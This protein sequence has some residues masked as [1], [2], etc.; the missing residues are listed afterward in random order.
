MRQGLS[1]MQAGQ[2]GFCPKCGHD[3]FTGAGSTTNKTPKPRYRCSSCGHR[4]TTPSLEKPTDAEV[5]P[6]RKKLPVAKRYI[7]TAAQ[8]ATPVHKP[9]WEA[10]QQAA[11][12]YDAEL[13]VVPGRYK[14]PTSQ[15]TQNNKEHD[16]W[17]SAV[18]KYLCDG[19]VNLNDRL[20]LLADMKVAWAAKTPLVG[21]DELS[22]DKCGIVGH[23]SRGMRSIATP[24]YKHPKIMLTT[25]ACT[26]PNYI[27]SKQGKIGMFN[28]CF[29]GLVVEISENDIFFV[30][31]L[32][33]TD[34]GHIIDLDVEFTPKEV[35]PS[36]PA[37]SVTM[38]D[39]HHRWILPKVV[40]ATFTD[41]DSLV[42]LLKPQYLFWHDVIDFHTRNHH[43]NGDWIVK[44][45][46]WKFNKESV[47]TEIDE[48]MRFVNE[49]TPNGRRSV[50]VSSNH[51]RAMERW[52]R[53]ADFRDDPVNTEFYLECALRAVR[54]ARVT[55]GGVD[56]NDP[57]VD[58]ARTLA[59]KNIQFLK[60]G[61]SFVLARVEYSFHGDEGPNG[62]RGST[63]NLSKIGVKTT[64]GHGHTAEIVN[65]C[66]SVGKSTGKLEYEGGGPSSH[67]NSHVVQ[68]ANGKRTIIFII[69][70]RFCL[71]RPRQGKKE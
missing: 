20:V 46:K 3:M 55:E 61:E 37:L 22:K 52:L 36:K 29:G 47:R 69:D 11:K 38:G 33:A 19:R 8:N 62:S 26:I 28:H 70:G 58:Y 45:T 15:W 30:R 34:D 40:S 6:M 41:P 24:Q 12:Y 66:Y 53:E 7:I 18:E 35:L 68:Y 44:F 43:H 42:N 1:K 32:N 49:H 21:M 23:G 27:D 65:G 10:L 57:F 67:S 2:N 50:I 59:N 54:S 71:P 63:K 16:W 25:G 60:P 17:D 48:A 64:K 14:N 31:E 13:V 51:D 56:Y 9:T 4:T 5:V 39:I